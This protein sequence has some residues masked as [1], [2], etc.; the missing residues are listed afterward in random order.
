MPNDHDCGLGPETLEN[1]F[2]DL[3]ALFT[4]CG[5]V[6]EV[7]VQIGVHSISVV[8]LGEQSSSSSVLLVYSTNTNHYYQSSVPRVRHCDNAHTIVIPQ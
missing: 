5:S 8:W 2:K 6:E 4:D 1:I 7:M 3:S